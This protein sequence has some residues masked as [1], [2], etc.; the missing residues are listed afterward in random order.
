MPPQNKQANTITSDSVAY[1]RQSLASEQHSPVFVNLTESM[2]ILQCAAPRK[3]TKFQMQTHRL[4]TKDKI[5]K[6]IPII[7]SLADLPRSVVRVQACLETPSSNRASRQHHLPEQSCGPERRYSTQQKSIP[8]S[9]MEDMISHGLL[10]CSGHEFLY[11]VRGLGTWRSNA[12]ET[13][14]CGAD[15]FCSCR[16]PLS[17]GS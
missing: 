16:P 7:T 10:L 1:P 11:Q 15:R 13:V 4:K 12:C 9:L 5:N 6:Q 3:G 14:P 17:V 2:T 8:D